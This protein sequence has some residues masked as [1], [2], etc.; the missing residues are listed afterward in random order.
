MPTY[1]IAFVVSDFASISGWTP[2]ASLL[3]QRVFARPNAIAN[4]GFALDTGLKALRAFQDYFQI[5]FALPKLDQVAVPDFDLIAM[6]NWGLVIYVE[7]YLLYNE[8][9]STFRD[10][11]NIATVLAHEYAHQYFGNLVTPKWWSCVWLSEG[12]A[13]LY[14]NIATN[15]VLGEIMQA[16]TSE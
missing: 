10:L 6:E 13:D 4:A 15:W 8:S 14:E 5:P 12:F 3:E 9:R 16:C 2:G 11:N 1:L 7:S